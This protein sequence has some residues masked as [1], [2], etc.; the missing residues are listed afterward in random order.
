MGATYD[1]CVAYVKKNASARSRRELLLPMSRRY[2]RGANASKSTNISVVF[3]SM[4][5]FLNLREI[6]R[7]YGCKG[8]TYLTIGLGHGPQD[9]ENRPFESVVHEYRHARESTWT[10]S[11]FYLV[12]VKS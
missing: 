4:P 11:P 7:L 9:V 1:E 3:Y 12:A 5:D 10:P 6:D 8:K 2:G